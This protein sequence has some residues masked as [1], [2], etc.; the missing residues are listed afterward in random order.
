MKTRLRL[1]KILLEA[2][3]LFSGTLVTRYFK[4][5]RKVCATCRKQ[6]GHGPSYYL[7]ISEDGRTRM[8]YVAKEH[9]E[10]VRKA[11]KESRFLRN[12]LQELAR[13]ELAKWRKQRRRRK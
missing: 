12:E 5:R 9:L 10:E 13:R 3:W 11:I 8:I 7:S 1:S 4:C 6:G 2:P